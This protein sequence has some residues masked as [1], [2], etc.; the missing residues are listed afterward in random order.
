M[1]DY[2]ILVMVFEDV[3]AAGWTGHAEHK[4]FQVQ[5]EVVV[6]AKILELLDQLGLDIETGYIVLDEEE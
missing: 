5:R 2:E 1:T 3:F 6:P 4:L